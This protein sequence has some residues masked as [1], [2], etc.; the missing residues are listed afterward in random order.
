MSYKKHLMNT[1]LGAVF[2]ALLVPGLANA[3][4]RI[5]IDN[6]DPSAFAPMYA[7][8]IDNG[9]SDYV[10]IV[11]YRDPA[12]VNPDF[13]L[14]SG[15]DIPGAFF[16]LPLT[17]E[18]FAIF[19]DAEHDLP[20]GIPPRQAKYSGD[21]VP[22]AFVERGIYDTIAV[23]GL[24]IGEFTPDMWGTATKFNEVLK[25]SPGPAKVGLLNIVAKGTL[26]ASGTPFS[27]RVTTQVFNGI[28][29]AERVFKL[30]FD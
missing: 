1:F 24:T 20:I 10:P 5:V 25:P 27:F 29:L 30:K 23:N 22:F 4:D 12:C 9:V 13:D 16:C 19:V 3:A 17:I 7:R 14:L 15:F 11:F 21:S 26:D 8:I 28:E 6:E 18:G 2:T